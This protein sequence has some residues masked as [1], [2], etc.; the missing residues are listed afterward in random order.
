VSGGNEVPNYKPTLNLPK[1]DFP[2]KAGLAA[3]EPRYIER[4][5]KDRL[6]QAIQ[7]QRSES[8]SFVL[9]DGPPY[10]NGNIHHG[11]VLNKVL[12]DFVVKFQSMNGKRSP[13]VPGWDCHGLPIE[14]EVDKELGK[15]KREMSQVEIRK[16]C[17]AYADRFVGIQRDDFKRLGIFAQW[18][19]PYTTM[20]YGYESQTVRLLGD[21]FKAGIV[22]KGLKPVH[23]SW[24]A[25]TALA[26]AEVEYDA[27]KAPSIYVKF[28]FDAAPKPIKDMAQG[29][30]LSVVIWTTTPWTLP[31]NLAIVLHPDFDYNVVG[32]NGDSKHA[33]EA[34]IV[35]DG[36]MKSTLKDCRIAEEDVEI[37]G[38]FK[39]HELVG[40]N[41]SDAPKL[42]AKHPFLDRESLLLPADYVTLEQGTGC[43]HTAPGHGQDDF[44]LGRSFGIDVLN[45]VDHRGRYTSKYAEM[46]G[47]H[48]FDANPMVVEKLDGL[49]RLLSA[50]GLKVK[51]DRYPHCWRTKT[52]I[53]FR[54][55][56]QWFISLDNPIKGEG[57]LD[58][59]DTLR[60]RALREIEEVEWVPHWGKA[61]I[62]GMMENRP[63]WCISRQRL[64]GVPITILYCDECHTDIIDHEIAYNVAD[65]ALEHGS[66]VWFEWGPEKLV[67]EGYV[68]PGCG[69]PPESFRKESDILD[70]W[71]DSGSSW[72]AVFDHKMKEGEVVDLYLEGSDQHR[73]WFNSSLLAGVGSRNHSPYKACLTHGFVTDNK[74]KKYS[75][76]SKNFVAPAKMIN[77]D[78]AEIL[79]LWV[80]AVDYRGDITLSPEILKTVRDAY[81]KLRN[82][83]R[84]ML[85]N[86][87]DFDPNAD[88]VAY[89][90]LSALDRW[91]L[92]KTDA[93]VGDL[94]GAYSGYEFHKIYHGLVRFATVELSNTYF[95]IIKDCLY[96]SGANDPAR[97]ATQTVLYE[98]L[99]AMVR[100]M[101][102]VLTFT[103]E[104]VWDHIGHREG[105]PSSVHLAD[106][107]RQNEAWQDPDLVEDI[108]A[109]IQV[110]SEFLR[111]LEPRKI[112]RKAERKPG[113]LRSN[114]EAV[115][116]L[117]AKAADHARLQKFS[118]SLS[119]IFGAR[120]VE[121]KVG[122]PS[123]SEQS[124]GDVQVE[125]AVTDE[126]RC[127]RCWRYGRG[128]GT[129]S[130]YK[131]LCTRCVDVVS[132]IG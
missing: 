66:D 93:L 46:E 73:G 129:H 14:H 84:F 22:Y 51:I 23:W 79:R 125:I 104:E 30:E 20:S 121:I 71:F 112:G 21:F 89:E 78:G 95:T 28:S 91:A 111:C 13:F 68:C 99:S 63:D 3:K 128:V 82:T 67:P 80:A 94:L 96:A 97:R 88:A 31:A 132:S 47:T 116:T 69:A 118:G 90:D 59:K 105:D 119:E 109:V 64:W 123:L 70:V 130:V 10:A 58:T 40:N 113:Q 57:G 102:P 61:R 115:I 65:H 53:I 87:D 48:V 76:S 110:R 100:L 44:A 107:P 32:V 9:H 25:Q 77:S 39:G 8:E 62:L 81:R 24:A 38:Q 7:D 26:D 45:P 19:D 83:C 33:G 41:V 4:W 34:L 124:V 5:E 18:E 35:A 103:A 52:P 37:L 120:S 43:V 56:E 114:E 108:D 126:E 11:H 98:I 6:Y 75:K 17:R 36:L 29:R 16:A 127:P 131:D 15:K 50:P 74:G 92:A 42:A 117:T 49:G 101:A 86:L 122:E 27:Y 85:G 106:M 72:S 12:K 1:T 60:G 2:M 55:T 54:A